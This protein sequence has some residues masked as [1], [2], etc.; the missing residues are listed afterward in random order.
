MNFHV[1]CD[2]SGSGR[3]DPRVLGP[4]HTTERSFGDITI[5]EDQ[6]NLFTALSLYQAYYTL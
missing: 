2:Q 6:S 4:S 1:A 3:P 5:C